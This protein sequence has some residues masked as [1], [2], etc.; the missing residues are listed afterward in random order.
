MECGAH[1]EVREKTE[2][3]DGVKERNQRQTDR[4]RQRQTQRGQREDRD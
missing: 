2:T 4:Q 3:E 1:R